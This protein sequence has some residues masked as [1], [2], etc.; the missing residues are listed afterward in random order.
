[1]SRT[2]KLLF[3]DKEKSQD[4]WGLSLAGKDAPRNFI[5][6]TTLPALVKP[7]TS[8]RL[9]KSDVCCADE[10]SGQKIFAHENVPKRT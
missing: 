1:M 2:A 8:L 7:H 3:L 10:I 5:G 4:R 9:S 6:P